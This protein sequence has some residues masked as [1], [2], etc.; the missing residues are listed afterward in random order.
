MVGH[1]AQARRLAALSRAHFHRGD[2]ARVDTAAVPGGHE[3]V[4]GPF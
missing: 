3:A 4:G 2:I 1:W